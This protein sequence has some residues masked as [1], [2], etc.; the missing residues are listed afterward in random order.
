MLHDMCDGHRHAVR[1]AMAWSLPVTEAQ[2]EWHSPRVWPIPTAVTRLWYHHHSDDSRQSHSIV[3]TRHCP[4]YTATAMPSI[5]RKGC[6]WA[7]GSKQAL[8]LC[9]CQRAWSCY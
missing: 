8:A 4:G 1:G 9:L 7:K 3:L 5:S 2:T 6:L